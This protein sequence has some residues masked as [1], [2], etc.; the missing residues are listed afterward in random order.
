MLKSVLA[1]EV[2]IDKILEMINETDYEKEEW[3]LDS[4]PNGHLIKNLS[5]TKMINEINHREPRGFSSTDTVE[6]FP[7]IKSNVGWH[8]SN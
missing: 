7:F 2:L 1:T 6:R 8:S 5:Y 4:Y 3:P